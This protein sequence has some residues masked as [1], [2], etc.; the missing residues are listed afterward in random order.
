MCKL[1]LVGLL[2][3]GL[4]DAPGIGDVEFVERFAPAHDALSF[5]EPCGLVVA[6]AR[7]LPAPGALAG[8]LVLDVDDGQPQQLDHGVVAGEMAAVPG[9]LPE[10]VIQALMLLVVYS[11][12]R[13]PGVKAKNGMNLSHAFSRT[14]MDLGYLFPSGL[15]LNSAS[16][17]NAA[18][19]FGAE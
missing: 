11:S 12:F 15:A 6:F 17:S 13:T 9:H 16:A 7:F 8:V 10:L 1:I 18:S 5:D 4:L 2:L 19:A 14:L 3:R